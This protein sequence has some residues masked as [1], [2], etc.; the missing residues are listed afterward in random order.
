MYSFLH[1]SG[2][3]P[4]SLPIQR[5]LR[6]LDPS[7]STLNYSMKKPSSVC[8]VL[9][10]GNIIYEMLC[11]H[12]YISA[13]FVCERGERGWP[14]FCM[15]LTQHNSANLH[16]RLRL[17]LF[18]YFTCV[19]ILESFKKFKFSLGLCLCAVL[20]MS[21]PRYFSI[22]SICFLTNCLKT[23]RFELSKESSCSSIGIINRSHQEQIIK[24]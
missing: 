10:L 4:R 17:S 11:L 5:M 6:N 1:L 22:E 14:V 12:T 9:I 18:F 24:L 19:L 23:N 15:A 16:N 2:E 7:A 8:T 3:A 21:N 13:L 20:A